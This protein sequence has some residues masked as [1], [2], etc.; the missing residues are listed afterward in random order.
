MRF[1]IPEGSLGEADLEELVDLELM[2]AIMGSGVVTSKVKERSLISGEVFPL[3]EDC[4]CECELAGVR[5]MFGTGKSR[6]W[7]YISVN[8]MLPSDSKPRELSNN[9]SVGAHKLPKVP[10]VVVGYAA[11]SLGTV[12]GV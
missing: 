11:Q 3:E 1:L 12:D 7:S 5:T 6:E 9:G 2:G 4:D 8:G 10:S